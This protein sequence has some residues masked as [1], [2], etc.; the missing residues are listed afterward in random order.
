MLCELFGVNRS[1]YRY[2]TVR[3]NSLS[4]EQLTLRAELK[5]FHR[6]SGGSAG[7]RSL[8]DMLT[9]AGYPLSRYRA[10]NLMTELELVS[11]QI[12]QHNYKKANKEHVEIPNILNRQFD[13]LSDSFGLNPP[14]YVCGLVLL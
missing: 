3:D 1:S 2:W 14:L 4:T 9:T 8:A 12:P 7:A 13:L 6:L 11:C 10:G 5:R